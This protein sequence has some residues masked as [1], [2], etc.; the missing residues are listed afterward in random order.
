MD[1]RAFQRRIEAIYFQK[2][3]ARGLEGTFMWF[4]EEVGELSRALRRMDD[5]ELKG[6]F[7]D[8]LAWLSTLASISG[9]DLEEA[10]RAKYE[11]GC[12]RCRAIPCACQEPRS[13]RTA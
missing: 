8:V 7:A 4:T 3:R 6:E 10:A 12:P 2:D 11:D 9:V 1:I 5:A 13:Q